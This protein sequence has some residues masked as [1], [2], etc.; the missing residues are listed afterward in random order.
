MILPISKF[1][2]LKN[3]F[4]K[5]ATICLE[6]LPL[7]VAITE[8]IQT[9]LLLN[10]CTFFTQNSSLTIKRNETN[11]MY[12]ET[13]WCRKIIILRWK[14][15]CDDVIL[16][17]II[18]ILNFEQL[19]GFP[20]ARTIAKCKKIQL[21]FASHTCTNCVA[22]YLFVPNNAHSEGDDGMEWSYIRTYISKM[23]LF[24][25]V[26]LSEMKCNRSWNDK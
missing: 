20:G 14:C 23:Y 4:I 6:T 11:F 21:L 12:K 5:Y 18:V 17:V 24:N 26:E 15:N 13:S 25:C 9:K 3:N 10:H 7:H 2:N 1:W 16:A 22:T 8:T 19:I